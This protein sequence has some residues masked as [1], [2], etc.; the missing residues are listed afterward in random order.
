M[1][2]VST[3][4]LLK[5][6]SLSWYRTEVAAILNDKA[7]CWMGAHLGHERLFLL[8]RAKTRPTSAV[9]TGPERK[10]SNRQISAADLRNRLA[11]LTQ[12]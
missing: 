2:R 8:H 7:L 6:R 4:N 11:K 1:R 10:K 5:E 9:A 12:H 3:S